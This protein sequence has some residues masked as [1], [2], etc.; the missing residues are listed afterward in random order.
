MRL[1]DQACGVVLYRQASGRHRPAFPVTSGVVRFYQVQAQ[2]VHTHEETGK[3][4]GC[5]AVHRIQSDSEFRK[6]SR[7]KRNA[8]RVIE[9]CPEEVLMD[10]PKRPPAQTDGRCHIRKPA[11][12]Q[13]AHLLSAMSRPA[14]VHEQHRQIRQGLSSPAD[15]RDRVP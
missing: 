5:R 1:A 15:G 3:R 14:S 4:H 12:H 7:C 8:D 13:S 2:R 9:K 6:C 10:V 11:V